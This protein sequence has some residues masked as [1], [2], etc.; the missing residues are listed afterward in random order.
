MLPDRQ[1]V[2]R[3]SNDSLPCWAPPPDTECIFR[4]LIAVELRAGRLTRMRRAR[5]VRYASQIGLS[6]VDTGRL[7]AECQSSHLDRTDSAS[8]QP[9]LRLVGVP[10]R[11]IAL[12]PRVAITTGILL[13]IIWMLR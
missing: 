7:I 1:F 6:A 9:N 5:I 11:R 13:L 4:E 8:E 12:R 2:G 10:A 3:F